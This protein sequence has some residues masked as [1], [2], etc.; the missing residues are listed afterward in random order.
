MLALV[1]SVA[2]GRQYRNLADVDPTTFTLLMCN[3]CPVLAI[4]ETGCMVH[5]EAHAPLTSECFT[6]H[7]HREKFLRAQI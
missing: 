1:L 3:G 4:N 6:N 5:D 7:R 2:R